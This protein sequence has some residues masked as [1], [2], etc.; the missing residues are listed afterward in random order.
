MTSTKASTANKTQIELFNKRVKKLPRKHQA[1]FDCLYLNRGIPV[2]KLDLFLELKEKGLY[3]D[4]VS[5]Y[6]SELRYRYGCIEIGK[7]KFVRTT[8]DGMDI[9]SWT[10]NDR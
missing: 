1:I 2:T 5:R 4:N 10:Y 8:A 3:A 6:V 9:Y 7:A